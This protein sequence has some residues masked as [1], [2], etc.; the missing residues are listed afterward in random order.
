MFEKLQW[1]FD[2]RNKKKEAHESAIYWKGYR[3]G[4]EFMRNK[5]KPQITGDIVKKQLN[6]IIERYGRSLD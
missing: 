2:Q 6:E 3:D 1:L 4:I 5:D